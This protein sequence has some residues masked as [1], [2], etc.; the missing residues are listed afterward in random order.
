VKELPNVLVC[1]LR[2]QDSREYTH[3]IVS[4]YLSSP[5]DVSRF[6]EVYKALTLSGTPPMT[7]STQRL[8]DISSEAA[9][10]TSATA[11]QVQHSEVNTGG[12]ASQG[13]HTG[14]HASQGTHTGGHA[15]QVTHTGEHASQET[16]TGGHASQETHT[17]GHASQGTHTGGHASQSQGTHN[18]PMNQSETYN[19]PTNHSDAYNPPTNHSETYN[20][21]TNHSADFLNPIYTTVNKPR[22][23]LAESP[24]HNGVQASQREINQ[25]LNRGGGMSEGHDRGNSPATGSNVPIGESHGNVTSWE[26]QGKTV[27]SGGAH[28]FNERENNSK[29]DNRRKFASVSTMTDMDD[30]RRVGDTQHTYSSDLPPEDTLYYYQA[31][32]F[33]RGDGV[34]MADVMCQTSFNPSSR[35]VTTTVVTSRI[36]DAVIVNQNNGI[37][38]E[39]YSRDKVKNSQRQYTNVAQDAVGNSIV[40]NGRSRHSVRRSRESVPVQESEGVGEDG[41]QERVVQRS[42]QETKENSAGVNGP[43]QGVVIPRRRTLI[44]NGFIRVTVE[45]PPDN[46]D[47][48]EWEG[49]QRAAPNHTTTNWR[50]VDDSDQHQASPSSSDGRDQHDGGDGEKPVALPRRRIV[51]E[52]YGRQPQESRHSLTGSDQNHRQSHAE[53]STSRAEGVK[54]DTERPVA[55]PRS[56]REPGQHDGPDRGP[57][58]SFGVQDYRGIQT[59]ASVSTFGGLDEQN[60]RKSYTK[61]P[62]TETIDA[63]RNIDAAV[64]DHS[65][66]ESSFSKKNSAASNGVRDVNSRSSKLDMN[67]DDNDSDDDVTIGLLWS[68]RKSKTTHAKEHTTIQDFHDTSPERDVTNHDS[69]VSYGDLHAADRNIDVSH[70]DPLHLEDRDVLVSHRRLQD[71]HH[72]QIDT[73]NVLAAHTIKIDPSSLSEIDSRTDETSRKINSRT[74]KKKDKKKDKKISTMESS[75]L[76]SNSPD[77]T[78]NQNYDSRITLTDTSIN[79]SSIKINKVQRSSDIPRRDGSPVLMRRNVDVRSSAGQDQRMSKSQDRY[80]GGGERGRYPVGQEYGLLASVDSFQILN[81]LPSKRIMS[82]Q[83]D[84]REYSGRPRFVD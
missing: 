12:H 34:V 33:Y 47:D 1:I 29:A 16:H 23:Y 41:R 21:P 77:K 20:P 74:N 69:R 65:R 64:R 13:T 66:G 81:E 40:E 7:P 59:Q 72:N 76:S 30:G 46:D 52:P 14:G 36:N 2:R 11:G 78:N 82:P 70:R 39:N 54:Q 18:P 31:K 62:A 48:S 38:R 55:R 26:F 42:L 79:P 49:A 35:G 25:R 19:P 44:D 27:A 84:R 15:S 4:F 63:D 68:K 50:R 61:V 32:V 73:S 9:A 45:P 83:P 24:E 17:V 43:A 51:R 67:G 28:R 56:Q 80:S 6:E 3:E 71:T 58:T 75:I 5:E 57:A 53:L 22:T 60:S 10:G 8:S 37:G